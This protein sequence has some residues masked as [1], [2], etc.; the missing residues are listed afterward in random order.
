MPTNYSPVDG[1]AGLILAAG[2]STRLGQP[3]AMLPFRGQPL[4]CH[5]VV[6]AAKLCGSGVMVVTGAAR[7]EVEQ[8]VQHSSAATASILVHNTRWQQGMGSS[9]AAGARRLA[10]L[11]GTCTGVMVMVCDQPRLGVSQFAGLAQLWQNEPATPVAAAYAGSTG[12]PAIFPRSWFARLAALQHDQG[13]RS[14]LRSC[15]ALRTLDMP[16]A[17][18]DIDTPDD[19]YLLD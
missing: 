14:L 2:A 19:L 13:A 4:I 5:T 16:E 9:L 1:L 12:V 18:Q 10:E 7:A 6:A 8:A 17:A 15:E 3:K 11:P